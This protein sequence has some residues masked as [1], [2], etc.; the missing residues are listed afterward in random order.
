[1]K[2]LC[3]VALVVMGACSPTDVC[4]QGIWLEASPADTTLTV[5]EAFE[6]QIH[7]ERC[8]D[9][10]LVEAV[11]ST[12]DVGVV[13]ITNGVVTAVGVGNAEVTAMAAGLTV[14]IAIEVVDQAA[15]ASTTHT[16]RLAPARPAAAPE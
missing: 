5:G 14:G 13:Q 16:K 7:V 1:M 12:E 3:A 8:P 4:H 11:L 9:P 2:W 6:P 10:R 15:G